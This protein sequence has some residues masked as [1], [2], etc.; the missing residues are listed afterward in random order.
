MKKFFLMDGF[1]FLYRAYYAFPEMKNFEGTNMNAVYGFLRMLLKRVA[2]RPEYLIIAWDSPEKTF[3]HEQLESY[4]AN[5]KKMEADFKDQIPL[6]R[7]I[8]EDLQIPSLAVPGY[9]ADDILASLIWKYKSVPDLELYLYSGDKDLK[10]V[11]DTNV[12]IV[13]PV[14]DVP[15]QTQDFI[16]EF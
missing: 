5:R 10:Q 12:F 13:D 3:R 11:L 16:K 8:V 1:A 4:K 15:Y 7:Q 9:E 6:L 2:K 14:K